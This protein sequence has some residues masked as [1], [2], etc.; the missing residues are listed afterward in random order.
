VDLDKILLE[1]AAA[2]G[3][4]FAIDHLRFISAPR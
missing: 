4:V 1:K 3:N 2:Q